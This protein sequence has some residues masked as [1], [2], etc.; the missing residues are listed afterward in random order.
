[1][2]GETGDWRLRWAGIYIHFI[3]LGGNVLFLCTLVC[4]E[5]NFQT[6]NFWGYPKRKRIFLVSAT[7][8]RVVKSGGGRK[9]TLVG[10]LTDCWSAGWSS[11]G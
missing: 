9:L 5:V 4:S 6:N 7:T 3:D 10:F 2:G 11:A 8:V 1:V